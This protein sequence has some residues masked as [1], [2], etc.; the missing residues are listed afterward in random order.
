[1]NTATQEVNESSIPEVNVTEYSINDLKIELNKVVWMYAAQDTTLRE[2]EDL[3][4]ELLR[5]FVANREKHG[6]AG[7]FGAA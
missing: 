5:L 4:S 7:T 6:L 1:M 3:A 2:A